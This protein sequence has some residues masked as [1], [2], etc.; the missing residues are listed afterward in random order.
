MA[1]A[2]YQK[3]RLLRA[4]YLLPFGMLVLFLGAL[5]A[6]FPRLHTPV[7]RTPSA[8]GVPASPAVQRLRAGAAGANLIII[9][10]DAAR[11]D[12]FTTFGHTRDTTPNIAKLFDDSILFTQAYTTFPATKAA[13]ASLFTSQFPDTHGTLTV[14]WSL[15]EESATLAERMRASGYVTAAFSANPLISECFRYD[16]GFDS[17][18]EVFRRAG[19]GPLDIGAVKAIWM[20]EAALDWIRAHKDKRFF[21]YLHFLEPH[22][23]YYSPPGFRERFRD[24]AGLRRYEAGS[25][26]RYDASLAYADRV[27]G[28]LLREIDGLGLLDRSVI[29]FMADHGE[30]FGEH[31]F[32]QHSTTVYQ[33]MIYVPVAFRLP[34]ACRASPRR[35]SE[36]FCITDIMP[37]LL[38]LMQIAPPDTMQ[39]RSRLPLL[40]GEEEK[41]PAFAV[42]RARGGDITG[43]KRHPKEVSYALTVP[44]YT[45]I[46]AERGRRV[47][48]Y[49]RDADPG[50]QHN[51]AGQKR[52][53]VKQLHRQFK[54]WGATQRGRPVVLRGGKVFATESSRPKLDD[55]TRRQ[56]K[57]LGY[58]R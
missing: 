46:L 9:L 10:L 22:Y 32:Y 41:T 35:R 19:L 43:G 31:G 40:A 1:S 6:R 11:A 26:L 7:F 56:L 52:D 30:A 44:H 16:R 42:T 50:E 25:S 45:L 4:R 33:E 51:I 48:L 20:F 54:A 8:A 58:L 14:P 15:S 3:R 29:V 2:R 55:R 5:L 17:F 34:S 13:V 18:H 49:D 37:T 12:H 39:G 36:V 38:D 27:V 28:R 24:S 53:L 21:A 47:E 57:S 23:P